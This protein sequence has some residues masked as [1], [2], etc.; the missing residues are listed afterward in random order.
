MLVLLNKEMEKT[1]QFVFYNGRKMNFHLHLIFNMYRN[2]ALTSIFSARDP[3]SHISS[4]CLC[5]ERERTRRF[6]LYVF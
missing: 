3:C 2:V 5:E 6:W 1:Y 4:V